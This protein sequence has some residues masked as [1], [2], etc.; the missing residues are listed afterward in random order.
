M[1]AIAKRTYVNKNSKALVKEGE[2]VEVTQKRF[3]E[4][5]EAGFGILLE[6]VKNEDDQKTKK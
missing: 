2:T 1:K 6:E 5:N 4:I 3:K